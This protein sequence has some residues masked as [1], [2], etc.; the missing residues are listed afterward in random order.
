MPD[1]G[2]PFFR[3][4]VAWL[5]VV[6]ILKVTAAVA[7]NYWLYF[8][9]DFSSDF[10]RNREAY[11][12][13]PYRVA[14][15]AHLVGSP[16]AILLGLLLMAPWLRRNWPRWHRWLGRVQAINVLAV[17]APS[18]LWM[19]AYTATG[20]VAAAA[21]ATLSL[22][23]GATIALGWRAAV[24]RRFADHEVWMTRNFLLLSAAIVLRVACGFASV[25]GLT[26]TSFDAVVSWAAWLF[27]LAVYELI[28]RPKS[29]LGHVTAP[30]PSIS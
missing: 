10:L 11:F 20:P 19:S 6:V 15:I 22:A 2:S 27:P 13:G 5:T 7:S 14:F 12:F 29:R 30:R 21:F 26:W 8:P 17:V 4:L 16:L 18:G 24:R 9:P 1:R 3:R 28:R 23:T 25:V